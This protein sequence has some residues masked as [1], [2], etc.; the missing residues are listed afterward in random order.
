MST[1]LSRRSMLTGALAL[2]AG[3]ALGAG[4]F[5]PSA[6]ANSDL[7]KLVAIDQNKSRFHGE[8]NCGPTSAVIAMVAA[9]KLPPHYISSVTGNYKAIEAMRVYCGLSPVGYPAIDNL[10][11]KWWGSAVG[12]LEL[13]LRK[14]GMRVDYVYGATA[15]TRAL[16]GNTVIYNV[17]HGRL[18]TGSSADYNYGHFIVLKGTRSDGRIAISDPAPWGY[19]SDGTYLRGYTWGQLDRARFVLPDKTS[20]QTPALVVSKA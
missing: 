18:L 11:D 8:R 4:A 16:Q 3:T 1:N 12:D 9:G 14:L 20:A 7:G 15:L 19:S 6:H 17:H 5:A 10:A 13:G 2:G